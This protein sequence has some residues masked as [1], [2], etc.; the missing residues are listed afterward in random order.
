M[1]LY[2]Q[3]KNYYGAFV[4]A[5]AIDNKL[6]KKGI[7]VMQL[8]NIAYENESYTDAIK[9]YNHV[10]V[11]SDDLRMQEKAEFSL[12]SSKEKKAINGLP[13]NKNTIKE[14]SNA[15][16]Q[17][18]QAFH[19]SIKLA[20][21]RITSYQKKL[22][23]RNLLY[24]DKL[25]IKLGSIWSPLASCGLYVPGGKALY[26]SSVLMNGIPATVAGVE[27]VAMVVPTPD[28]EINPLVLAAADIAGITEIY[29]V[30]G[31]QA[32][33]ALAFGTETIDPVDKITGPGNAFVA[34]AKRQVCG[35]VGEA[36]AL[37]RATMHLWQVV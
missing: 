10:A 36:T 32:V 28:G 29:R 2:I 35:R 37:Q 22:I 19:D 11:E 17:C 5:K 25:G 24:K 8:A 30:G 34:S 16:S 4:Q 15:L 26:P 31:A 6:N 18:S 3:K 23:P 1:W 33:G 20:V 12:L 7:S 13:I 14:I 21:Q 9:F 27:R